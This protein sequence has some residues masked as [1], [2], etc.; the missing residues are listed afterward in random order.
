MQGIHLISNGRLTEKELDFVARNMELLDFFHLREKKK[1]AQEIADLA[2]RLMDTDVPRERI[3]IN[4]R[5]D[6]AHVKRCGGAQLAYHSLTIANVKACFPHLLV[7]K[8]VHSLAE[9]LDAEQQ[10]A[11][12]LLYGHIFPSNSKRGAEPRGVAALAE[13]TRNVSLPVIAIGGIHTSNVHQVLAAGANGI[14]I[15]SGIWDAEDPVK[16]LKHYRDVFDKVEG[17]VV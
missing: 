15:M 17:G 1:T 2:D 11:D 7:G 10:G 5:V 12:Y 14:A 4:D 9:A 3:I 6:V 8:S 13:L 16:A